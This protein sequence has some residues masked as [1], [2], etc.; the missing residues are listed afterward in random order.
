[1]S[2]IILLK[3]QCWIFLHLNLTIS[4][5]FKKI[6]NTFE[7]RGQAR[8]VIRAGMDKNQ[9]YKKGL[10]HVSLDPLDIFLALARPGLDPSPQMIT[11]N[12]NS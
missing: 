2:K 8:P 5:F 9:V 3:F 7:A 10:G 4:I 12:T 1:M 6:Q 11:F